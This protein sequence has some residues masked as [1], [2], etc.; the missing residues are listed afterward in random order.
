M[1]IIQEH[2]VNACNDAITL[3][4]DEPDAKN[5][6]AS[7][8]YE[9]EHT[10]PL[11]N[12]GMPALQSLHFQHGP[13]KEV[14]VNGITHEVLI[15]ILIDRLRGFQSSPFS[16]RENAVALTKLEEARMWLESRTKG[17]IA[18]GVEGTNQK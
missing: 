18:R 6:N 14:G 12:D 1:R 8:A 3:R 4:A 5:G 9:M 7:H 15:A 11:Y 13:I 2:Q 10:H 16:C 17:R